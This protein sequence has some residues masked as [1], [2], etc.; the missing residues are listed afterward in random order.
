[1]QLPVLTSVNDY[2]IGVCSLL[3]AQEKKGKQKNAILY[4]HLKNENTFMFLKKGKRNWTFYVLCYF[5]KILVKFFPLD[6]YMI[7]VRN[8][9][10]N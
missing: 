4:F 6:I 7:E 5:S 8:G 2:G 1:M 10:T 3:Q 9:G